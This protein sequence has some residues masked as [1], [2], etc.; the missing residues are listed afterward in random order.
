M[1]KLCAFAD[2]AADS[3]DGQIIALKRNGINLI[4]LRGV[5]GKNVVDFTESEAHEYAER[6]KSEGVSVWSIGSP[7]GKSDIEEDEAVY[8]ARLHKLCKTAEIF[9]CQ[10]VRAFSFFNAYGKRDEVMKRLEETVK[11]AREYGKKIC[12]ENEKDIYGDTLKRT[13]DIINS[14]DGI[15]SVYDPANFI[16]CGEEAEETISALFEKTY[17]FHVKDVIKE[18][19]EI[20]PAGYGDGK[21]AEIVRRIK[22]DTVFTL[23]P[24]LAVFKGYSSIDKTEMKNKYNFA[25]SSEAFDCAVRAFKDILFGA[26]Y[27][28]TTGGFEK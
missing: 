14:V 4:E 6:L 9:H 7:L 27:K 16:Q 11:I 24:H 19:S 15:Y 1:I 8:F 12:H 2:E 3:L 26:G 28:E 20:V 5:D 21:I 10:N 22:G 25:N 23:E 17:Y 13:L 18:T